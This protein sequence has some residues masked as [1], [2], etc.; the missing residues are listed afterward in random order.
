[1]CGIAA[2]L[3]S[4]ASRPRM[5]AMLSA[6]AY[7][8]PDDRGIA[9]FADGQALLGHNRLSIID[10][11]PAGHQ[12]M[13]S[14]DGRFHVILNGEIYNY[15]ELRRE[16]DSTFGFRSRS[17][18]EVLLASYQKWGAGCLDRLIG[19]FAFA[20]WDDKER[21][22]F[23]ARDRFGV[24]PLYSHV[25]ADGSLAIASEITALH[26]AGVPRRPDETTWARY[27]FEG[28]SDHS[29]ATF[30]E[31]V[32]ALPP[33][34]SLT[35]R[36]GRLQTQKWYDLAERS[37]LDLDT[38]PVEA[39]IARYGELLD[40]SVS[41]RF[42]ADVPVGIAVSG[43]LDSSILVGLIRKLHGP[44]VDLRAFTFITGDDR[45]DELPWVEEMLAGTQIRLTKCL[46]R[47][48]DVPEL[49]ESIQES[50]HDRS[51]GFRPWPTRASSRHARTTA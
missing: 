23:A 19:M 9:E 27:L 37:G 4:S 31:G 11:S 18:T 14:G 1:M 29:T 3:G 13:V 39:V 45:Y 36:A 44:E 15:P 34:H 8:G 40:E 26:A 5:N 20:V 7:R 12:P 38:T 30:W 51:A 24:K 17:D 28:I 10:L 48:S 16:L 41:L 35:W 25:F 42:R 47:P 43:G 50:Q 21:E 22:L 6:M 2:L 46:L 32:S 33:G 49:A